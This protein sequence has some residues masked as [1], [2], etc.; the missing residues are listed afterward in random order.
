MDLLGL[1]NQLIAANTVSDVGTAAAVE[2]LKPLYQLADL[3]VQVLADPAQPTQQNL[4][5]TLRG[6]DPRGLLLVTHLDTVDP[7]PPEFWTETGGSGCVVRFSCWARIR[8]KWALWELT[9]LF[10]ARPSK[11]GS[12]LVPSPLSCKSSGRTRGTRWWNWRSKFS[13]LRRSPV[14]L[15][16]WSSTG[17]APIP[18]LRIWESTRSKWR[19]RQC[20]AR[21][22]AAWKAALRPTKFPIDAW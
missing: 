16:G 17:A 22:F 7:G 19:C 5:G 9:N 11:R 3:E 4:L 1:S 15:S 14:L 20:A 6:A 21:R 18:Q 8:K 2:I 12:L 10:R 13:R